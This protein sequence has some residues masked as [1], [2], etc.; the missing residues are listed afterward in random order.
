MTVPVS[1]MTAQFANTD[2]RY[3]AIGMDANTNGYAAN[4]TLIHL[5]ANTESRFWVDV[6]GNVLANGN[7][8]ANGSVN[9]AGDLVLVG[10]IVIG[11]PDADLTLANSA[12]VNNTLYS[13]NVRANNIN[14][15]DIHVST[16]NADSILVGGESI[17][18]IVSGQQTI[19][20]PAGVMIPYDTGPDAN[21][22]YT[23]SSRGFYKT[24]DFSTSTQQYAQ[25]CILMPKSWD[26][27]TDMYAQFIWDNNTSGTAGVVWGIGSIAL[28]DD[29][30]LGISAPTYR[31]VADYAGTT[32]RDI[33][34]TNEI[35]FTVGG[36]PVAE[37]FIT[38]VVTR[39]T[40]NGTDTHGGFAQLHGV[41][42][43][44]TTDAATDD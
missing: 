19:Y 17:S 42:L 36:S 43:H 18:Q 11:D 13:N 12:F 37:E 28:A 32:V 23:S 15:N 14:T 6:D 39:A 10:S 5:K 27:T 22:W 35:N 9:I 8:Q 33:R 21:T 40:A 34:I 3:D 30:N 31:Y 25:F 26:E 16:M 41:K 2:Y 20:V 4:S 38:F 7:I 24:L 1:N 44:Y 29:D